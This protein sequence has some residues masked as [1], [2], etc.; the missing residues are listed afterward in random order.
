MKQLLSIAAGLLVAWSLP[1]QAQDARLAAQNKLSDGDFESGSPSYF[2]ASGAGATWSTE[3][4]R[5]A[6]Y[7]LKLSG[8]GEA[9]WT[10]TEAVRN[11]VP[12][13]PGNADL[14]F[15]AFVWADGVNTSPTSDAEKFQLVYS[16][17]D[18][19][20]NDLLG[21]EVVLD[22]PQDA[23]STGGWVEVSTADLA[24]ITLSADAASATITVRKGASA[25]G[26]MYVDDFF[27]RTGTPDTW[28]GDI[29]NANVDVSGG[30]YYYWDNFP[31]GGDWPSTQPFE[32]TVT[33]DDAHAGDHSLRIEQLDPTA[34]E[35]VAI[36]ERVPVTPGVPVLVSYWLKTEGNED[37]S[38]IGQGDNNVG[39]TALFYDNLQGGAA[40]WGELGG[41][42][43][44]LNGEYNPNVIPLLPQQADN[45]WT[46][47]SFVVYPRAEA[48]GMELRL[49]YWHSFTGVTYWDDVFVGD[50]P[51][52][53]M[54]L[55]NLVSEMGF[56]G[57]T[58]SYWAASGAGA[59]WSTEQSRSPNY[60]L[61]LSGTGEAS[62]TMGEAVRNWSPR[63]PGNADLEFGAFVWADG[64]NTS[65]TS[66]AEKF[67]LVYSFRDAAG[68]DLLG[69]EVVL[70]LPQDAA[71]TG[72]W[73][74]VSTADLAPI[75]LSADA[76]SATITVRKGASA[77]GTMYVDDFFVRTGT[78]DTWP[79][80][81]FNATVDV[82]GGWYFYIPDAGT[83]V[84]GWP[85]TQPF[86]LS[87]TMAEA[88]TG[89]ASLLI[90]QNLSDAPEAVGI[91]ERVP[92]TPGEPVLVS[93]WL[94][95]EGNEDPTTI[96][97]G[98]NNVG[99][100]ALF[101]SQMESGAAGWGEL[102]GLDIRLNGEYNPNV[103]PLYPQ[104]ADNDWTNYAFVVYPRTE[105]VGMELRVR[106]WHTFTG[107]TYWDDVSITN[108]GGDALVMA[109]AGEAGPQRP[110]GAASER[111]LLGNAP[112]PFRDGTLVRFALPEAAV[113]TLE[114]YDML[115]RRVSVLADR[116]AFSTGEHARELS[117]ADLPA[118]SYLVVL[119]TP[120]HSEARS[121]TVVR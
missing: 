84:D 79:G 113:V 60:S 116:E 4:S 70:D 10:M 82:P 97:Q 15:G 63:F 45:G 36:S 41:L 3:Q 74:E 39:L 94:K 16:F 19:A 56:E 43:I 119:R 112:N 55:P 108:V 29:F 87:K 53:A 2:E 35:A 62:W 24:P 98:D 105:A 106:Y 22:L 48:V 90:E 76:A 78:P 40:G 95:S 50:V 33:G 54:E 14:E 72:G 42:D 81:I 7:S 9:S 64:V 26:T 5:T 83:G 58:P 75:T 6:D 73:V 8:T 89:D 100:T 18:A 103:I 121:I 32:V 101:Y 99:L 68:N 114:V 86:F 34:T 20:G 25:S 11:W 77:S 27:V 66:D 59:T 31:R 1:V 57:D 44:R 107:A 51:D 17:R 65:P 110:D 85:E 80:D 52:V 118:G 61:K 28:P 67:Q 23:A 92:V 104:T 91:T 12:A 109:T 69:Q 102:G 46:Q 115:G 37:P 47:Y 111:W 88:H 21:Q 93:F 38:T 13:F 120:S 71:S 49:R 117:G 96:G 30:W